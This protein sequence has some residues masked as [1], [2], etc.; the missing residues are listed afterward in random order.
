MQLKKLGPYLK[1]YTGYCILGPLC[2]LIEAILEL[3]LPLMMAK[4]IDQG[5]IAEDSGYVWQMGWK[6]LGV[7]ALGLV[8]ALV[9][10]YVASI[11]SQGFGCAVR[12]S[13][14][15]PACPTPNGTGLAHHLLSTGL[16]VTLTSSNTRWPC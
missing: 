12:F 14:K 6:M 9:C 16:P 5:V 1:P 8:S 15:L 3:Y 10:Q 11:T 2:K 7:V 13:R 4:V